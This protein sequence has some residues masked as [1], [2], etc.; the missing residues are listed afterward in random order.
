M[1]CFLLL[2]VVVARNFISNLGSKLS[3]TENSLVANAPIAKGESVLQSNLLISSFDSFYLSPYLQLVPPEIL[4]MTNLLYQRFANNNSFGEY[5]KHSPNTTCLQAWP[6]HLKSQFGKKRIFK[7]QPKEVVELETTFEYF[8]QVTQNLSMPEEMKTYEN[9]KWSY[10]AMNSKSIGFSKQAWKEF[11]NL[12][13]SQTTN[14]SGLAVVALVD[15]VGHAPSHTHCPVIVEPN[16]V[17]LQAGR[18]FTA[19]EKFVCSFKTLTNIETLAFKGLVLEKNPDDSFPLVV[20]SKNS[21]KGKPLPFS[22]CKYTLKSSELSLPL[23]SSLLETNS[24]SKAL[25]SYRSSLKLLFHKNSLRILKR[26]EKSLV[27]SY[28]I[29]ELQSLHWHL[30]LLDKQLLKVVKSLINV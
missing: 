12:N 4:L 20:E 29:S 11:N 1:W 7:T 15:L 30:W 13:F 6:R 3:Y 10:C 2:K 5:L 16:R 17:T 24:P 23:I 8:L 9:W 22:K 18:N 27:N 26:S 19:G 21:C 25:L 28:L 14:E